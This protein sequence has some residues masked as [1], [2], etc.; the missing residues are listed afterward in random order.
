MYHSVSDDPETGVHPYFRTCVSP[1]RFAEQMAFLADHGY[2]GVTL[3][4]GLA[5]LREEKEKT[6]SG[7][8]KIEGRKG[9]QQ[10]TESDLS[11]PPSALSL[12]NGSQLSALSFQLSAFSFQLSPLL[13]SV[14]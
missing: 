3:S 11:S 4:E 1:A 6:E 7:K 5:W 13:P 12:E 8:Q 14:P 9:E 10:E 2:R